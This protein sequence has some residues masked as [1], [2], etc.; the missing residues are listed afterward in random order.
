MHFLLQNKSKFA[1]S[2]KNGV[3]ISF[4]RAF[5]VLF[6]MRKYFFEAFPKK[7][8]V[9]AMMTSYLKIILS[10]KEIIQTKTNR[11]NGFISEKFRIQN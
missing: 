4:L 3:K 10:D 6:F 11:V 5:N 8:Q 1:K 7:I 9:P 2:S